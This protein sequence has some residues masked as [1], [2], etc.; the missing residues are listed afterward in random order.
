MSVAKVGSQEASY[1]LLLAFQT[2]VRISRLRTRGPQRNEMLYKISKSSEISENFRMLAEI[3]R[4]FDFWKD[5]LYFRK[6]P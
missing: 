2:A 1:Y 4:D 3:S 6:K 5:L